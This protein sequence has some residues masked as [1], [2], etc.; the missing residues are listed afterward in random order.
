MLCKC[1]ITRDS[2]RERRDAKVC[3]TFAGKTE[4]FHRVAAASLR[5]TFKMF[6]STKSSSRG[7]CDT[8]DERL[9]CIHALAYEKHEVEFVRISHGTPRSDRGY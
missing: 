4:C 2:R 6:V 8:F 3:E 7:N 5:L 1:R 9:A